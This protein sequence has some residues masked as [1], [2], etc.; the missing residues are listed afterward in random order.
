MVKDPKKI[1]LGPK[2]QKKGQKTRR[3]T[4]KPLKSKFALL[5]PLNYLLLV[6]KLDLINYPLN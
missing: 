4:K 2:Y 1:P 5:I 6:R 3:K